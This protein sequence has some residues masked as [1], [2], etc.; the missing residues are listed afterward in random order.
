MTHVRYMDRIRDYYLAEGYD[1]PYRW[2]HYEAVPFAPLAK[3]LADC[4]VALI[5]TSDVSVK[6]ADGAGPSAQ[7]VT[8]GNVYAIPS[9]TPIERLYSRQESYDRHATDLNDVNAY[10][11]LTRLAELTAAERIGGVTK[12]FL[13]VNRGYSQKLMLE[14][15]APQVLELCRQ[16]AA[17]VALLTPV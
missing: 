12:D 6:R 4:R 11:P 8:V 1:K 9:D 3:P 2:A 14:T 16:Q 5:S 17:D 15:S 13:N 10:L 7:E